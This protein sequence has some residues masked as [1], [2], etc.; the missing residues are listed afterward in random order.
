MTQGNNAVSQFFPAEAKHA[1]PSSKP[2]TSE[3]EVE[4]KA[5]LLLSSAIRPSNSV[6]SVNSDRKHGEAAY[7][8]FRTVEDLSSSARAFYKAVGWYMP[9][10]F[11]HRPLATK[12]ILGIGEAAGLSIDTM[13]N[14]I[15]MLEQRIVSWQKK[16]QPGT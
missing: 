6:A 4:E 9:F 10:Y 11:Y 8:A 15:Y 13:T 12:L 1:L 3:V 14:A 5:R 16:T 2:D 7:E